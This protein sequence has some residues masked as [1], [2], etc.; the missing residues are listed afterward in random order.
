MRPRGVA[1][2][3]L[4]LACTERGPPPGA[5]APNAAAESLYA[6][7]SYDSAQ[8]IWTRALAS[9][10]RGSLDE[11]H[12]VAKLANIAYNRGDDATARR[13]GDSALAIRLRL[14]AAPVQVAESRNAL[15][16]VA[17]HD[18]RLAD[19]RR[20][21]D[22]ATAGYREAH[23]ERGIAKTS[24]NL[25]NIAVEFGRFGEAKER[26]ALTRTSGKALGDARIA[27]RA[28]TNLAMVEVL[29]G[30]PVVA[31]SLIAEARALALQAGD[32]VNEENALGQLAL[33]RAAL[34]EPGRALATAD[35]A[36][37]VARRHGMRDSEASDL[38]VLATLE[39]VAG[40]PDR[41]VG[42]YA[43]ARALYD[44]LEL[45]VE[46]ATVL[47]HESLVRASRGAYGQARADVERALARHRDGNAVLEAFE[48]LIAL[49]QLDVD[50]GALSTAA[51]AL[52]DAE[53]LGVRL[54]GSHVRV[55]L[56]LARARLRDARHEP[57]AA[58]AALR[59]ISGD[60]ET[61]DAQ[62]TLDAD[63][64]RTRSYAALG[65]LDSAVAAGHRAAAAIERVGST[66]T[67]LT[68][69]VGYHTERH[70]ILADVVLTLLRA[71]SA[72]AAFRIAEVS[73]GEALR[74][75][76]ARVRQTVGEA[77][78]SLTTGAAAERERLLREIDALVERLAAI[79]QRPRAERGAEWSSTSGD[80]T[81]RIRDARARY[82]ALILRQ[83]EEATVDPRRTLIA[84]TPVSAA[85]V[86]AVLRPAEALVEYF[87]TRDTLIA[88]VV[89]RER[90]RAIAIPVQ[91]DDLERRVRLVRGLIREPDGS[92]ARD[93]FA[94]LDALLIAPVLATGA[95]TGTTHLLIVPHGG[96]S[97][98]PF[99][100][101]R[102]ARTGRRLAERYML[103]ALPAAGML[104]S[105]R[106]AGRT[107]TAP[108]GRTAVLAP[109][110]DRLPATETEASALSR[111]MPNATVY[112]GVAATE[113]R[114]RRLLGQ[115]APLHLAT[116]G[117]FNASN[118]MFSSV[119]LAAGR[120]GSD[121]DGRL[122]VHEV[123]DIAVR[124]ALVFLSGCET[125]LGAAGTT[126]F[127]RTED[128]VTLAEAFL[129]SG[130]AGVVA[131]LW[132]VDDAGSAHFA[133]RFYAHLASMPPAEALATAQQDLMKEP[134]WAHPYYWA[135]YTLV[136][137]G[138]S[139][140][141]E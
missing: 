67:S 2:A 41:A 13:L 84:A 69:R 100:A 39:T 23:D 115:P 77:T 93:A 73:R 107:A 58:L 90:L 45:P 66:L 99:A 82:E 22:L 35:S 34:G 78:R 137:D 106:T 92:D 57:A 48:D 19:A 12:L 25:G 70:R 96:L 80:L 27:G 26:F 47:R 46:A 11:A 136:G 6:H 119:I 21:L 3:V 64:L 128:V 135:A 28:T 109:F 33:A 37:D 127:D 126:A 31:V 133:E 63:W 117:E 18:G 5:I 102:E 16:L 83:S 65:R 44:S 108:M 85:A 101:L 20:L 97:Y 49:V 87:A 52:A 125:G 30:D 7:G 114:V 140:R 94:A 60:L 8:V 130:A 71:G 1:L 103:E 104:P 38:L 112:R 32:P 56:A 55:A 118:S 24:N 88:F 105:L 43:A 120:G 129:L 75:D 40:V 123:L 79:E 53:R 4:A 81:R 9:T 131:T 95:L 89:T 113:A 50:G 54:D 61:G 98:L 17:W 68:L 29:S 76:L 121:D 122:E 141:H 132:R 72:D 110:P 10:A 138:D 74:A 134:R 36:L 14:R 86:R 62:S 139:T 51:N 59:D 15:G 111:L 116:H 91:R 42:H 124:S